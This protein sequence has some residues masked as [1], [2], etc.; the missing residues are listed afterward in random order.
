MNLVQCLAD[1]PDFIADAFADLLR[2][3]VARS[4]PHNSWEELF[5]IA[6]CRHNII[7]NSSYSWWGAWLNPAK[8]KRIIAPARWFTPDKLAACNVL[9]IYPDY[10]ILLK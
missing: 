7:A 10:W 5:L 8:D 9:D 1:E 4:D 3:H 6:R 2:D